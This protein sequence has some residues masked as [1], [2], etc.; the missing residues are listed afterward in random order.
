[1]PTAQRSKNTKNL[2]STR[3]PRLFRANEVKAHANFLEIVSQYTRL[4]RTRNQYVGRC[5]FHSERHASFYVHPQR[6]LFH[7]FGC[8]AGGDVLTFLIMITR[9]FFRE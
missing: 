2:A 7:C 5:P 8:G 1:M 3:M 6:K 9:V 4:R